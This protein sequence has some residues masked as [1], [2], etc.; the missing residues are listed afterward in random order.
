MTTITKEIIFYPFYQY[1]SL[2]ILSL[3]FPHAR[4]DRLISRLLCIQLSTGVVLNLTSFLLINMGSCWRLVGSFSY[5]CPPIPSHHW[6]MCPSV[7]LWYIYMGYTSCWLRHAPFDLCAAPVSIY[8]SLSMQV[9]M[10]INYGWTGVRGPC[11]YDLVENIIERM[12]WGEWNLMIF[13]W[14]EGVIIIGPIGVGWGRD[15][16]DRF[17]Q[18]CTETAIHVGEVEIRRMKIIRIFK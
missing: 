2:S 1:H 8:Y 15:L 13:D 12:R 14:V 5:F 9:R 17:C 16:S 18:N 7:C 10:F 11:F 4:L 6:S 3:I